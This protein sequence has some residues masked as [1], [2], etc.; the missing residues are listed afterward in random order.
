MKISSLHTIVNISGKDHEDGDFLKDLNKNSIEVIENAYIEPGVTSMKPG[1]VLQFERLG[2]F[3]IDAVDNSQESIQSF[4][5]IPIKFNRVVTL[6][7]SRNTNEKKK[8]LFLI[9]IFIF[10][11]LLT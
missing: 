10:L 9:I 3:S 5:N 2:Y 1:D 4:K 7:V 8:I 6:K 11:I